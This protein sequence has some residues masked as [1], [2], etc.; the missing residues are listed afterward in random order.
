MAQ[1][2]GSLLR[3]LR[4]APQSPTVARYNPEST[5]VGIL[6]AVQGKRQRVLGPLV[7]SGARD[8]LEVA[9]PSVFCQSSGHGRPFRAAI[10]SCARCSSWIG[11][12]AVYMYK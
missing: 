7:H 1:S 11:S 8:I 2:L 3:R 4:G 9:L 5:G 12:R 6:S 10:L